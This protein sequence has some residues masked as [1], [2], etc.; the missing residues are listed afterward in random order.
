M[1][2]PNAPGDLALVQAFINT[3]DLESGDDELASPAA[4]GRWLAEHELLSR[5]TV[6]SVDDRIRAQAVREALRALLSANAGEPLD[7]TAV[8]TLNTHARNASLAAEFDARGHASLEPVPIGVSA[9]IARLLAIVV[10]AMVDGTWSRLKVCRRTQC[11]WAYYD[12]SKNRSGAWCSMAVCGNR[13]KVR[14]YQQR[15]RSGSR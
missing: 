1:A 4:L 9:A 13:T 3:F 15:R 10:T 11:R 8:K 7:P 12:T 14:A 2:R 6:V 5:D